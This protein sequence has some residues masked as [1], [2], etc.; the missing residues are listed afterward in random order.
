MGIKKVK[1]HIFLNAIILLVSALAMAKENI[2]K[3]PLE[4]EIVKNSAGMPKNRIIRIFLE[5]S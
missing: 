4:K 2:E 1:T 5:A 3:K